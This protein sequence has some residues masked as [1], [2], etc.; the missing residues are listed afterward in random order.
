MVVAFDKP[1]SDV[2]LVERHDLPSHGLL[3][4]GDRVE[5]NARIGGSEL[6]GKVVIDHIDAICIRACYVVLVTVVAI[7]RFTI[8]SWK[9]QRIRVGVLDLRA[10]DRSFGSWTCQPASTEIHRRT[11]AATW[12]ACRCDGR[13][14]GVVDRIVIT[15][16]KPQRCQ[17]QRTGRW[18]GRI[19]QRIEIAFESQGYTIERC[20]VVHTDRT[21]GDIV[22]SVE[23]VIRVNQL[24]VNWLDCFNVV[25]FVTVEVDIDNV[26]ELLL[27][28]SC[29]YDRLRHN[30]LDGWSKIQIESNASRHSAVES[31]SI[32]IAECERSCAED[33]DQVGIIREGFCKTDDDFALGVPQSDVGW[34]DELIV[35]TGENQWRIRGRVAADAGQTITADEPCND[36]FLSFCRRIDRIDHFANGGLSA[37]VA[38]E[39][40]ANR[41]AAYRNI[42]WGWSYETSRCK[43]DPNTVSRSGR[44]ARNEFRLKVRKPGV[45]VRRGAS[46]T[47]SQ[48][49]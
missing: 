15:D 22:A 43:F 7:A 21:E 26:S 27:G 11:K 42:R 12:V 5:L 3:D 4:L 24:V 13:D 36:Q 28:S 35:T 1:H 25:E 6:I 29:R 14:R 39:L 34:R 31:K 40:N 10:D 20:I 30:S 47:G 44:T 18:I 45:E 17:G 32:D 16:A 49:R 33:I 38:V 46:S 9:I 23:C 8:G 19:D 37:R 2:L 48:K 41:A